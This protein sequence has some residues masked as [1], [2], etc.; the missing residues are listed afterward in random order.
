MS[1]ILFFMLKAYGRETCVRSF[2]TRDLASLYSVAFF[3][4]TTSLMVAF[5]VDFYKASYFWC[6]EIQRNMSLFS[7]FWDDVFTFV[8]GGPCDGW[9]LAEQV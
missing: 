5:F 4:L 6:C 1:W 2:F 8:D 9:C 7:F 3:Q